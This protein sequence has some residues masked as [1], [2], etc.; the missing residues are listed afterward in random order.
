MDLCERCLGRR[1]IG[2]LGNEAQTAAAGQYVLEHK[3]EPVAPE[4]CAVCENRFSDAGVWR[5]VAVAALAGYEFESFQFGCVFPSACEKAEKAHGE[6]N[7]EVGDSIRTESNRL[8]APMVAEATGATWSTDGRPDVAVTVD[9]RF[10]TANVISNSVYVLGRYTKH[11]REVPQTHWPC[12]TCQGLGC[13]D[14][15]D[16]GW[17]YEF[18]VEQR[19]GDIIAPAFGSTS[20]SF[21]GAGREDID[22]LMLGT[23]RPFVLE[24]KNP[25]VRRLDAQKL[26]ALIEAIEIAKDDSGVGV[27]ML[28]MTEKD[29][30]QEIKDGAYNKEYLAHCET[31]AELTEEQVLA[32]ASEMTG[33][34]LQQRTP[35]RVSHRRADLVRERRIHHMIVES[36]DDANHFS[37][38]VLADSGAYIKEMVNGDDGRT[39]PCLSDI[40]G[41]PTTVAYL[42]VVAILD[43]ADDA[44]GTK[45]LNSEV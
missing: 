17:M 31:E 15:E 2:A 1:L 6:L 27:T 24:L 41:T 20:Y 40:L 8:V 21:H 36:Y 11:S 26:T 28:E 25:R 33:A 30:V 35:E 7:P 38:R 43:G 13:L 4:N 16:K 29:K 5:D 19:I 45:T 12:K 23:G 3:V 32:G 14:C 9:T 10:W 44:P 22:A 39:T 18:S 37:V 42:D 34:M